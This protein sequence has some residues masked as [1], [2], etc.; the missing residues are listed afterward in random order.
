MVACYGTTVADNGVNI[1]NR[2]SINHRSP[3]TADTAAHCQRA[4]TAVTS[5][6]RAEV[7]FKRLAFYDVLA[8]IMKPSSLGSALCLS[9]LL[10]LQYHSFTSSLD[11]SVMF[12]AVH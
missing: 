10:F 9:Q 11:R 7:S 8:E 2:A 6:P 1:A 3:L 12:V 5:N 4:S